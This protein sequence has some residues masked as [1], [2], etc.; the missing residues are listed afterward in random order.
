MPDT[1]KL[2]TDLCDADLCATDDLPQYGREI[3]YLDEAEAGY[4]DW[5]RR[6]EENDI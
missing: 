5:L 1:P 3:L 4:Q 6:I 2:I